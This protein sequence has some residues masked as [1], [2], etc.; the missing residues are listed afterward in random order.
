MRRQRGRTSASHAVDG[1]PSLTNGLESPDP[2]EFGRRTDR[3]LEDRDEFVRHP[4]V[5]DLR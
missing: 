3:D 1:Q 5:L 2:A 4:H